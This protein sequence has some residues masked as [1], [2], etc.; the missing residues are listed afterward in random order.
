MSTSTGLSSAQLAPLTYVGYATIY[1]QTKRT[2]LF[3]CFAVALLPTTVWVL[4]LSIPHGVH[5]VVPTH[6][7]FFWVVCHP[8]RTFPQ[9]SLSR[10]PRIGFPLSPSSDH[11]L[12]PLTY[13][14][15]PP[16]LAGY[17]LVKFGP[18]ACSTSA[19][20]QNLPAAFAVV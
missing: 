12:L 9:K 19:C 14:P 2:I 20:V 10:N 3:I 5:L 7:C 16:V 13:D 18:Y 1:H 17:R 6:S 15:P 11:T 4:S 8:N